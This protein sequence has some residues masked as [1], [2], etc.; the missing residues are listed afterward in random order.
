MARLLAVVADL[1]DS[2]GA[3]LGEMAHFTAVVAFE[4]LATVSGLV[5]VAATRVALWRAAGSATAHTAVAVS[6][7]VADLAAVEARRS[8]VVRRIRAVSQE[9][10]SFAAVVAG[11]L[12]FRF[13]A[14]L[15]QMAV[16]Y[17][18]SLVYSAARTVSTTST[19]ARNCSTRG[20]QV[21]GIP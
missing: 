1:F 19:Y 11:L 10:A 9:V 8:A 20:S 21:W 18:T 12:L 13:L 6:G 14:F 5:T 17:S 7:D 4:A 2:L 16:L 15:A 3:I